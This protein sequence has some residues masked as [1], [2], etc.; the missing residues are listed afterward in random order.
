MLGNSLSMRLALVLSAL[1]A[2]GLTEPALAQDGSTAGPAEV[3]ANIHAAGVRV[4][5][6]GDE[7]RDARVE[8]ELREPAE[9]WRPAHPLQRT[10]GGLFVGSLFDLEPDAAYEARL[11]LRDPDNAGEAS[12][13][14]A[15]RTRPDGPSPPAAP[16]ELWVSAAR[17]ADSNPGSFERPL[18]RLQAAMDRAGPGSLVRV[19]AGTYREAVRV[20]RSGAPDD[21][22][23]LRAEPGAILAGDEPG[24]A[25]G[26][27]VWAH[28][29]DGVYWTPFHGEC[30]YLA[31]GDVRLYD[32]ASL[33]SLEAEDG[34][35][36]GQRGVLPG[37]FFADEGAGRLYLRLPDRSDPTGQPIHAAV[38]PGGIQ[39]DGAHDVVLEGLEIRH[40][41]TVEYSGFGVD[42]RAS[43]RAVVRACRIHHLNSGVRVR[44]G[45]ASCLVEHNEISDTS[46]WTW[47]WASVKAHTPEASA[48]SISGGPGCVVR[49]N[50]LRGTFNGIYTGEFS[51]TPDPALASE[52]DV[53]GNELREHADDGLEP[54]GACVNVRFWDNELTDVYN[55]ISLA[56]IQRGPTWLVRNRIQGYT[57]HALKLHNG[58]SGPILVYHT[59][60]L[61]AVDRP[62]AQAWAPSAPFGPLVA[63]NNVWAAHRYVIEYGGASLLGPVDLDHDLLW[64]DRTDA[65][66]IL[67][68]LNE[69]YADLEAFRAATGLELHGLFGRP[70]FEDEAAGDLTPAAG[71]LLVDRGALIP[72]LTTPGRVPDGRPD[73]GAMERGAGPGPDGGPDGEADGDGAQDGTA[74]GQ[75]DGE[76]PPADGA[77]DGGPEPDAGDPPGPELDGACGCSGQPAGPGLWLL[78]AAALRRRRR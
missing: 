20:T 75:A 11:T 73:L 17:G 35:Q 54:E 50:R 43:D 49:S 14:V 51:D 66:P 4:A 70:T 48:V 42:V 1:V 64:T 2:L 8:L 12:Q 34:G 29:G 30:R 37:G 33:A 58:S 3:H 68:W 60:A 7:D 22:L 76:L 74:D 23:W 5:V 55:A 38:L 61:P 78:L 69:R 25:A 71:S 53:H 77:G 18:A 27:A 36:A 46:V 59:T 47:P 24:L 31:W 28:L 65:G 6:Q 44:R 57:G 72:G 52:T 63:R 13:V 56:P 26:Q 67:K 39:L 45:S 16:V 62:A 40:Y 15:F 21:P 10:A 9:A 41:G 32:Y 19:E